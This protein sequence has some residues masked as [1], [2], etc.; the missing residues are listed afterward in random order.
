M[1]KTVK[2]R[3]DNRNEL[4]RMLPQAR[5]TNFLCHV[6]RRFVVRDNR[7]SQIRKREEVS[8]P[9]SLIDHYRE[10]NARLIQALQFALSTGKEVESKGFFSYVSLM[11]SRYVYCSGSSLGCG[12]TSERTG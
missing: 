1:N 7:G 10:E 11:L 6:T 9:A 5:D 12:G 8:A 2:K 3:K 4:I